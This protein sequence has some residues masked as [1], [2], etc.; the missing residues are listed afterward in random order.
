MKQILILTFLLI[1]S[2][3]GRTQ[4]II[5]PGK[6][7]TTRT[8]SGYQFY[9]SEQPKYTCYPRPDS[10]YIQLSIYCFNTN[11]TEVINMDNH[12]TITIDIKGKVIV[13]SS[14]IWVFP[15]KTSRT[16]FKPICFNGNITDCYEII[17]R[18]STENP[19]TIPV[20][21]NVD[22][23]YIN[24]NVSGI[25]VVLN[26]P[27]FTPQYVFNYTSSFSYLIPNGMY[28]I[29]VILSDGSIYDLG[30]IVN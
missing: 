20:V 29:Y 27:D 5:N 24:S 10:S 7:D 16:D 1:L 6:V 23:G 22:N 21:I 18:L 4:C 8:I 12:D 2:F 14:I 13:A 19:P 28:Y 30:V 26:Y 3:T 15:N 9:L 25:L 11:N 17:P